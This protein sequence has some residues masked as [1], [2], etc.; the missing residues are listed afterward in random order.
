MLSINN[1]T[2]TASTAA[3]N[4]ANYRNGTETDV[5]PQIASNS[6]LRINSDESVASPNNMSNEL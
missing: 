2:G 5:L 4:S 6:K 1:N 3:T